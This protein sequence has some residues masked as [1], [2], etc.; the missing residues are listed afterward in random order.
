MGNQLLCD[1]SGQALG[2]AHSHA[3]NAVL[4]E[5]D[6]RG[7]HQIG[8][9]G[10]KQIDR[11]DVGLEPALNQVHD[12]GQRLRRVAPLGNQSGDFLESPQRRSVLGRDRF[13]N[14][15]RFLRVSGALFESKNAAF[16]PSR[17][18]GKI[19]VLGTGTRSSRPHARFPSFTIVT[20]RPATIH[21][22]LTP[23]RRERRNPP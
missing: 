20:L 14:A 17:K 21:K 18:P 15:H 4:L 1:E 19:Q 11:A 9:I 8:P 12:V 13:A 10:L 16:R 7:Q 6:R 2:Q 3:A 22:C 23:D 5:A